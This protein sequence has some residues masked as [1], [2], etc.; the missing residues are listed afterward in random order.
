MAEISID[1]KALETA[2]MAVLKDFQRA[3]VNRIDELYR[4]GHN[5]ILVA[6]EVGLG[7]TLI[8]RGTVIKAA[9]LRREE[10]DDLVKVVYI[11][12]N[13][14][15]AAQN[16]SKLQVSDK[17]TKE[18]TGTSRLSMQHLN[19]FMQEQDEAILS[20]Y[21]RLIPLTPD[22]S[23]RM[24]SGTGMVDERALMFA[25]LRRTPEM[26]TYIS[27]LEIAMVDNAVSA[28]GWAKE[29]QENLVLGCDAKTAGTYL[30][31]MV[32]KIS[33]QLLQGKLLEDVV[34]LC[35][36]IRENGGLRVKD[37]KAIGRLRVAFARICVDL[38]NPDLV[39]MDEF[40]RFKYLMDMDEET[41][42]GMLAKRFMSNR[43]V[44]MLLLS[45]TPYKLY[46]TMEEINE[47]A[48]DEHYS[49]FFRVMGFLI[50]NP[51]KNRDFRQIWNSWSMKIRE[52]SFAD[53][54]VIEVKKTAEDAMYGNV[55]RT[56]RISAEHSADII[57]DSSKVT[58]LMVGQ[59][60]IRSFIQAQQLLDVM[61]INL[62]LPVDYVKSCPYLLSFMRDYQ[63]KRKVEAYFRNNPDDVKKANKDCLWLKRNIIDN[64]DKVDFGNARLELV[65][66]HAFSQNAEMLLW[67]PP[68]KPYYAMG[69]VFKDSACFSK[70]LV[71]SSW[72]MVPRMIASLLSYEAERKTVGK[73][74][75]RAKREELRDARYYPPTGSRYP[76]ARLNFSASGGEPKGMSLFC[77]IYPSESLASCF[78][79]ID[80]LNRNIS[81]TVLMKEV[82][83]NI[84]SKIESLAIVE[85]SAGIADN[86]WYYLAPLL[87]DSTS[88]VEQWLRGG[89]MLSEYEEDEPAARGAKTIDPGKGKKGF[90]LH[91]EQIRVLWKER[92]GQLG[93]KPDD[94]LDILTDMAIA[95]PAIC[96]YR[97][98]ATACVN[99]EHEGLEVVPEIVMP[100]QIAKVF[101][102]R[103]NSPEA[104]AVIENHY[105]KSGDDAHWKNLLN[106][107]VDGNLQAVFDEY[108]HMLV[109]SNGLEHSHQ[110]RYRLHRLMLDSM[111]VRTV[112][113]TVDTFNNFKQRME[114]GK[115]KN[116]TIR[117]HFAVAFTKGDGNEDKDADRK[118]AVRNAF[119]SPFRP[120]V[121]ASTSIGQEGLDFHYYCRKIVHWNLPSNPIDLEQREG[122]I[123]RFKCL[124]IR[125]NVAKRYGDSAAGN[126]ENDIWKEM[127]ERALVSEKSDASSELIPFWCLGDHVDMLKIERIV[128]MYPL[129]RDG[130]SYE[131]LIRILSLYRLTLGQARQEEL[132]EYIFKNCGEEEEKELKKFFIN[133]SPYVRGRRI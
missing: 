109:E 45:A 58:P 43:S 125:Q 104:I 30:Q 133:L 35:K 106:Y 56:E 5:R 98:Y 92:T 28:W 85:E 91:L 100:S 37:T 69:G 2:N 124:A 62:S 121:L 79:P 26:A 88:Y 24:T 25:I 63:M 41:E 22:T 89:T 81:R 96:A 18:E 9:I 53:V 68:S 130:T 65:A 95:S 61:G 77:L 72:E 70:I 38:L 97:T 54:T 107:C 110:K 118:K 90:L 94:L 128:P 114:K 119:N 66:E 50:H 80:A 6:D 59:R 14:A 13:Q 112:P 113:Y 103:M 17:M 74:A 73:L 10:G 126:F 102:N 123:N 111:N 4:S 27:E 49:E 1:L 48:I 8:A 40:Q 122:R 29:R 86:R 60:D 117:T 64:Y 42:T 93:R 31:H 75:K 87:M 105:A 19:I 84:S 78:V 116:T 46:S 3:T 115:S 127:F 39:I 47:N 20:G 132:L 12:S 51:E 120:F 23:F 21:V 101:L 131:R 7:K 71:F 57:D 52:I 99:N 129:S 44:R 108:A 55:C 36:H 15:I 32:S 11:C 16:L 33:E 82:M 67:V 76:A 34:D 83:A